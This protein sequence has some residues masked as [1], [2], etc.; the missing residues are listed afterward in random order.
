LQ[1]N[2]G[3]YVGVFAEEIYAVAQKSSV[4][5]PMK[6]QGAGFILTSKDTEKLSCAY[7]FQLK[8]LHDHLS[9]RLGNMSIVTSIQVQLL[10][11]WVVF[12]LAGWWLTVAENQHQD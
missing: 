9:K 8:V 12:A 10:V 11:F 2:C 6:I 5:I 7:N 4:E 1:P 3:I